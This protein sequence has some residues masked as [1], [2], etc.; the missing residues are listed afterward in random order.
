M[1]EQTTIALR[2]LTLFVALQVFNI[3]L[4]LNDAAIGKS[5]YTYIDEVETVVEFIMETCL[6]YQNVIPE[7]Q[8]PAGILDFEE[9][10]KHISE[11]RIFVNTRSF[12]PGL[13]YK[14]NCFTKSLCYKEYISEV[15]TPPPKA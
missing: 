5:S 7:T 11:K 2:L 6:N 9:E 8:I 4:N 10:E 12:V 15:V 13:L 1:K 3:S 14:K